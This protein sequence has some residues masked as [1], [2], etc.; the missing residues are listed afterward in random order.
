MPRYLITDSRLEREPFGRRRRI[1]DTRLAGFQVVISSRSKTFIVRTARLHKT[2]GRWPLVQAEDARGAALGVLRD[3]GAG[4]ATPDARPGVKVPTLQ[5]AFESYLVAKNLKPKSVETYRAV[6][7]ANAP[8][9]LKW[10]LSAI[11]MA[12]YAER[13]RAMA[14]KSQANLHA[15]L[16][17][18]IYVHTNAALGLALANP[19][20]TLRKLAGLYKIEP[21]TRTIAEDRLRAWYAAVSALRNRV[22]ADLFEALLIT[23]T[24]RDEMR[25]LRW[26]DVDP[27][28]AT[29]RIPDTKNGRPHVLPIGPRMGELLGRRRVADGG[30]E[31]VFPIKEDM[32]YHNAKKV[33]AASG[34]AFS[35]HDLRRTFATIS[36]RVL[37]DELMV[38]ALLNHAP[39]GVTQRHYIVSDV[40]SL[41]RPLRAIEARIGALLETPGYEKGEARSRRTQ[42]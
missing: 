40:E 14:S 10:P 8:D 17:A 2:I 38:K 21:K 35:P 39:S 19:A 33:T 13:F 42:S 7:K 11:T 30:G 34:V 41:R 37:K 31:L 15:R 27:E 12:A 28:S 9:L 36:A 20:A 18:A 3:H 5:Q 32:I 23:G 25:C 1:L 24:R 4:V 16:V 29:I 6:L 26:C 22:A